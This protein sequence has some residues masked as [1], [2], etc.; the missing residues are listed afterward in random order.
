MIEKTISRR[1]TAYWYDLDAGEPWETI[2]PEHLAEFGYVPST[3]LTAATA[4]AADLA[5]R[6]ASTEVFLASAREHSRAKEVELE[7]ERESHAGTF[8]KLKEAEKR[9]IEFRERLDA[10]LAAIQCKSVPEALGKLAEARGRLTRYAALERAARAMPYAARSLHLSQ[11]L[12]ALAPAAPAADPHADFGDALDYAVKA[13]AKPATC[14]E[15][16]DLFAGECIVGRP[17]PRYKDDPACDKFTRRLPVILCDSCDR[18]CDCDGQG[19]T[20]C[21]GH[22]PAA[23]GVDNG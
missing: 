14:G 20:S 11:A 18:D 21:R 23:Q 5:E 22:R 3:S 4:H 10:Q 8:G 19:Y 16:S 17:H 6:L 2:E 1:L 9:Y 12:D 7:V 13:A 15:C